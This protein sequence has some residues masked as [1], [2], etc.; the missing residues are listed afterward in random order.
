MNQAVNRSTNKSMQH[1]LWFCV[2]GVPLGDIHLHLAE[3]GKSLVAAWEAGLPVL[4]R[5]LCLSFPVQLLVLLEEVDLWG[6]P[7]PFIM[8]LG[9]LQ[10]FKQIH[11]FESMP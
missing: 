7:G 6:L 8:A 1:Q 11:L 3:R 10:H 5:V 2:A 9:K 4:H